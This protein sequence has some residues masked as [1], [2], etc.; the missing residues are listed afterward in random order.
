VKE[1]GPSRAGKRSAAAHP[2]AVVI[3]QLHTDAYTS[4]L[5]TNVV[6]KIV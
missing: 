5:I 3:D 2:N 1:L 6:H 4:D